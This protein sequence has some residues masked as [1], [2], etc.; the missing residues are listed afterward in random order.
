V[1]LN[2]NTFKY[3]TYKENFSSG[4]HGLITIIGSPRTYFQHEYFEF[5]GDMSKDLVDYFGENYYI[6]AGNYDYYTEDIYSG[7]YL[8]DYTP[9]D[10]AVSQILIQR[11]S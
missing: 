7:Y 4:G 2:K 11:T 8:Y 6:D 3:N 10:L 9:E 5:N 1:D